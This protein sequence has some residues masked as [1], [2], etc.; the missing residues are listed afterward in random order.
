LQFIKQR[1][2]G[3]H[4]EWCISRRERGNS[5]GVTVAAELTAR[6][7]DLQTSL[8]KEGDRPR[9]LTILAEP[10]R[11]TANA[12]TSSTWIGG[13]D[14]KELA[15]LR[16]SQAPKEYAASLSRLCQELMIL[17]IP[18]FAAIDGDAIGG[19]AEL[20]IAAD[21][22]LMTAAS[23]LN[24][25]QQRVGLA[26]GYGTCV[27]LV[28]LV[29]LGKAQE[30]LLTAKNVEAKEALTLGLAH[31]VADD[32]SELYD[33]LGGMR[34]LL[35]SFSPEAVAAQKNMLH[36]AVNL[37]PGAAAAEELRLFAKIWRN[38]LHASVLA[39]F[40]TGSKV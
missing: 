17:P 21:L 25:K 14:L 28:Q 18:V 30:I 40:G 19:G 1:F 32:S 34:D 33:A 39:R 12:G 2:V 26:T 23:T 4:C 24:F 6:M 15:E 9:S 7:R 10:R 37:A 11:N 22:R 31:R 3:L 16:D 36:N 20:A 27:R 35:A 38:P 13:G 29:G 8:R 5:L